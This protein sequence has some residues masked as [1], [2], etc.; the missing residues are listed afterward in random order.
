MAAIRSANTKPEIVVRRLLYGMGFR[1]RLHDKNLVG[2]PDIVLRKYKA[3]IFIHGCFWHHHEKCSRSFLPKSNK[4][5]WLP[6]IHGNVTRD[7]ENERNLK[8]LGWQV[9]KIWECDVKKRQ[10]LLANLLLRK[11]ST[12]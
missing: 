4:Q 12:I 10:K 11:L 8:K 9:I 7:K 1:Y 3:V 2:K 6:K 5:Y